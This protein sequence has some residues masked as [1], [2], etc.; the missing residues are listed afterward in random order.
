MIVDSVLVGFALI[1]QSARLPGAGM[2]LLRIQFSVSADRSFV[3][4]RQI[5]LFSLLLARGLRDVSL[6]SQDA[7][8][9]PVMH[10]HVSVS[11]SSTIFLLLR[12]EFHQPPSRFTA[13]SV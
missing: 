8:L 1:V 11:I 3:R 13:R 5:I 9:V 6:L 2:I 10:G 4:V 12:V 7:G